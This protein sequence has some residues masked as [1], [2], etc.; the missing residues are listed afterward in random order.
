MLNSTAYMLHLLTTCTP[1]ST[2]CPVHSTRYIHSTLHT[3]HFALGT[4]HSAVQILHSALQSLHYTH[5]LQASQTSHHTHHTR[6]I[7]HTI[8]VQL[9]Y[10]PQFTHLAPTRHSALHTSPS[11]L[12]REGYFFSF[13]FR[14]FFF[15]F[16]ALLLFCFSLLLCF[17]AF[18]LA[19]FSAFF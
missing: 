6:R 1:P 19:C 11:T 9:H 16:P 10:S 3:P 15:W 17:S 7:P 14:V 13:F 4:L 18:Q 8:T 12:S 2:H 5:I